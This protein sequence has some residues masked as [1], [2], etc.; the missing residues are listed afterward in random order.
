[1]TREEREKQL[2][3]LPISEQQVIYMRLT[4]L[5]P[6]EQPT[7]GIMFVPAI[8]KLEFPDQK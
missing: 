4:N 7:P 1:M 8:L 5:K 2:R 3:S 6:G